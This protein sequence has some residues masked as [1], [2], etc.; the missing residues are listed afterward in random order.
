MFH[1]DHIGA[2][3]GQ[4][5]GTERPRQNMGDVDY[6]YA[7]ER[8]RHRGLLSIFT[9]NGSLKRD[10]RCVTGA[11][12]H[13]LADAMR[14]SARSCPCNSPTI[15]RIDRAVSGLLDARRG[16]PSLVRLP[17]NTLRQHGHSGTHTSCQKPT[18]RFVIRLLRQHATDVRLASSA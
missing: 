15:P 12:T 8:T 1:L 6:P 18:L 4:L 11:I 5:I 10:V 2:E 7:F 13:L 3:H 9:L 14:S 17:S 16:R